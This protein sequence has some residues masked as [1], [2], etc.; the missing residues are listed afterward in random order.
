MN[1][2]PS[3]LEQKHR[4][5]QK[6]S[7]VWDNCGD[8]ALLELLGIL[9]S[10]EPHDAALVPDWRLEQI[11]DGKLDPEVTEKLNACQ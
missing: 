11:L 10:Q 5:I 8:Q 9:A 7:A 2:R 6:L 1:S 4:I 3:R